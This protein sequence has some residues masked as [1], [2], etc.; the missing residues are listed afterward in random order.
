ML[1]SNEPAARNIISVIS[2]CGSAKEV[3]MAV[4]EAVE[5]LEHSL[6]NDG[7]ESDADGKGDLQE[8]SNKQ[9]PSSP[10]DQLILLIEIYAAGEQTSLFSWYHNLGPEA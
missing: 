4:Q 6:E 3:V 5:R 10:L 7:E 2:E 9:L 1:L 8:S